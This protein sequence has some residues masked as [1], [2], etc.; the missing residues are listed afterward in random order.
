MVAEK[1][2]RSVKPKGFLSA[3]S[4]KLHTPRWLFVL[5][6]TVLILRI[7]S[8]FEPY[9]YGDEM[10]Y[11]TLGEAIRQGIPLYSGIH[12]NK[13]PL[14]YIIAA[15]SSS[16][17]WFKAVLAIWHLVTVY[18]F[19]K[20][21]KVLFPKKLRLQKIATVIFAIL[22]TLP[23][24]EGNI[25]NAELFMIG[26]II[27]AFLLVLSK[28]L[29]FRN[30]FSA[31]IL[32]SI[33]TLFKIPAAFDLLAV[34]FLWSITAK[35][36][37]RKSLVEITVKTSYLVFGF[38]A[39]I[40]I[41]FLWYSI[42]G[43]FNEYLVA[44]FLQNVGYLSTWRPA[45]VQKS[46]LIRNGPLVA[47]ALIVGFGLAL[48][49]WKRKRLSKQFIFT[50]AW[51][52]LTLFAVTLSERPYPHYLIQSVA[53]ISVLL[54]MLFTLKTKEQ[55]LTI[56]PLALAFFVPVYFKFWYYPTTTYYFRFISFA[57]TQITKD[58]YFASFGGQVLR[59][60]EISDYVVGATRPKDK[61]FVWGDGTSIYALSRRF[62]PG[63]YVA[64]Y[65]IR[66]F[67]T[68]AETV[69]ELELDM[70]KLI[71]TLPEAPPFSELTLFLRENYILVETI[72][73]A[74][75]WHVLS[76]NVRSLIA[77]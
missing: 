12:D 70:P 53:P 35:K 11:L 40:G 55:T 77:S 63:K 57:T 58:E 48:L 31:G 30:L 41:S 9:S 6:I 66:D 51:L 4:N 67:S 21:A 56:I 74:S 34:V 49:F 16:L 65:H 44:A 18:L 20:L 68:P 17:F 62:P 3:L 10:I 24:L 75:I 32:F 76:P 8:F 71:I 29:T 46:F 27:A 39:P 15:I 69:A 23:L 7:P 36:L 22:T 25:V 59:N 38:L 73:G 50:T 72:D 14:L 19:W 52:L 13:P 42:N 60:Y 37:N 43:A 5:L 64:D 45:V 33:A 54:A 26:P 47:R 61:V 2:K 28:K 1:Q